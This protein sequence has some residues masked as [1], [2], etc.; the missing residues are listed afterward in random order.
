M[1]VDIA[2]IR[3]RAVEEEAKQLARSQQGFSYWSPKAGQNRVRL[4]PPWTTEGKNRDSFFREIYVHFG[5]GP[6]EAKRTYSCPAK[7]PDSEAK[8]CPICDWV[9]ALRDTGGA[10]EQ[11]AAE[12]IRAKQRFYSNIVDLTDPVFV[13]KD[14]TEWKARNSGK[15]CPFKIG[16]TKVQVFTYGPTIW[17]DLMAIFLDA[18]VDVT[19]LNTGRDINIKREGEGMR[20]KY[21][22]R[23]ALEVKAFSPIGRAVSEILINLDAIMPFAPAQALQDAVQGDA[24]PPADAPP[25]LAQNQNKGAASQNPAMQGRAQAPANRQ[26]PKAKPEEKPP[27]CFKD[28]TTV[29]AE[30][31]ECVGGEKEGQQYD[32]CPFYDACSEARQEAE[33]PKPTPSRRGRRADTTQSSAVDDLETEMR[34]QLRGR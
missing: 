5:V 25:A 19:D 4:L 15:E 32:N 23:P 34:N 21:S 13:E 33:K 6:E 7:T 29:S 27:A 9:K 30:D 1:A 24:F 3:E 14:I 22:A 2:K 26:L 11:E 16:D 20:T 17:N 8:S 10:A 31:A 18:N 12:S 28:L